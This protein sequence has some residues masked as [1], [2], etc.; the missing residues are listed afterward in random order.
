[1]NRFEANEMISAGLG[2]VHHSRVPRKLKA[3]AEIKPMR[4][5][6]RNLSL[7]GLRSA[8]QP[9][10]SEGVYLSISVAQGSPWLL[11]DHSDPAIVHKPSRVRL[12][13]LRKEKQ[14]KERQKHS[15]LLPWSNDISS[16]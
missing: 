16:R 7:K 9:I 15:P 12:P 11:R 13:P 3:R 5:E 10:K 8:L 1:M 2:P 4:A 6:R 14:P